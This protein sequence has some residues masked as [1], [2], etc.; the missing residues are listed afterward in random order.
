[1]S[2][3]DPMKRRLT[4]TV[5][6]TPLMTLT[7]DLGLSI[8]VSMI[9]YVRLMT[10]TSSR[11]VLEKSKRSKP[12]KCLE[13]IDIRSRKKDPRKRIRSAAVLCYN[14]NANAGADG[15]VPHHARCG[16]DEAAQTCLCIHGLDVAFAA[17]AFA[18]P[19]VPSPQSQ[20]SSLT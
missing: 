20:H 19:G 16:G 13:K 9:E 2:E 12:E 17:V 3:L 18:I 14:P 10:R 8:R 15:Q 7:T 11:L 6:A 5:Y 1:M 4:W